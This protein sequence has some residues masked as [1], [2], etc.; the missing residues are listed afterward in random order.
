MPMV[1]EA[2]FSSLSGIHCRTYLAGEINLAEVFCK[3]FPE[4]LVLHLVHCINLPYP[5]SYLI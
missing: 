3:S 5:I 1:S 4:I 2:R